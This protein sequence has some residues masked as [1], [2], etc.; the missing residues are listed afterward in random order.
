MKTEKKARSAMGQLLLADLEG[1]PSCGPCEGARADRGLPG[2]SSM[3]LVRSLPTESRGRRQVVFEAPPSH[4]RPAAAA[5]AT[6]VTAVPSPL[7]RSLLSRHG[8]PNSTGAALTAP[9][10]SHPTQLHPME[11]QLCRHCPHHPCGPQEPSVHPTSPHRT[12][13]LRTLTPPPQWLLSTLDPPN[14]TP[15]PLP[16]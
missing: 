11:P 7:P 5:Q 16:L 8:N 6:W 10:Q 4:S 3:L 14:L 1:A 2:P 12:S 13:T 15:S 9:K